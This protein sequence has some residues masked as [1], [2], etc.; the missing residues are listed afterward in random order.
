MPDLVCEMND[1]IRQAEAAGLCP[2]EVKKAKR[3]KEDLSDARSAGNASLAVGG[4][5]IIGGAQC[6]T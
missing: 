6:D 4:L 2:E 1:L 3:A 5:L